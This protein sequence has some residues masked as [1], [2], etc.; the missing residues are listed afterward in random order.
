MRVSSAAE[1]RQVLQGYQFRRLFTVRLVAQF[2]DGLFQAALAS[3]VFFSPESAA[4]AGSAAAA[5]VIMLGPY[6]LLGPVV[7]VALD[8]VPRR[9]ILLFAPLLRSGLA[10]MTAGIIWQL[11]LGP[12]L[13]LTVIFSLAVNRF[14]L[15]ALGASLPRVVS[16]DQLLVANSITPTL[17]TISVVLGG[18]LG[19]FVRRGL[20]DSGFTDALILLLAALGYFIA[21]ACSLRIPAGL[22]GPQL[23]SP[24]LGYQF[25]LYSTSFPTQLRRAVQELSAALRLLRRLHGVLLVLVLM[26]VTRWGL[27]CNTISALLL[28]RG[29][30]AGAT[31][32]AGL[33]LLAALIAASTVG[34][35]AAVLLTSAAVARWGQAIW[36]LVCMLIAGLA[37]LALVATP[38]ISRLLSAAVF[39]AFAGQ[40][41]KICAD[42]TVQEQVPDDFRGRI[43]AI[44]DGVFNLA[45]VG[46]SLMAALILPNSG[47]SRILPSLLALSYFL[48]ASGCSIH[49]LRSSA[50]AISAAKGPDSM[51]RASK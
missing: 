17:G 28:A 5:I 46:G 27:A 6:T 43:F 41:L 40:S 24:I 50:R 29:L 11:G 4:S 9:A 49:H 12:W 18:L 21:S 2:A 51:R 45:L 34:F 33:D 15:S 31:T 22:L 14:F 16:A 7:G 1:F 30:L 25:R 26:A 23:R 10:L 13:Y 8:R 19:Y 42:A 48:A 20:P 37:Q 38:T 3:L 47:V 36:L 35:A 39:L 44:Y 32:T